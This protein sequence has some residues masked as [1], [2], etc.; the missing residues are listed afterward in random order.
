MDR[1]LDGIVG[2]NVRQLWDMGKRPFATV[3]SYQLLQRHERKR[4][5]RE[6]KKRWLVDVG[7]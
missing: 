4:N 7:M 3:E 5:K 1:G 2:D 6:G